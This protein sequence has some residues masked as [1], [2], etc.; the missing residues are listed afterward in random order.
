MSDEPFI[1]F[2][3]RFENSRVRKRFLSQ[4][5]PMCKLLIRYGMEVRFAE[6]LISIEKQDLQF[7]VFLEEGERRYSELD[8]IFLVSDARRKG[9]VAANQMRGILRTLV[10]WGAL[11][12]DE[13]PSEEIDKAVDEAR[14]KCAGCC[15]AQMFGERFKQC[16][17]CRDNDMAARLPEFKGFYCCMD[18]QR[19]DWTRH[20]VEDH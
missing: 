5:I 17:T 2:A 8:M 9:S 19:R 15:R 10:R 11:T 14:I 12:K 20:K 7:F 13:I 6:T 18:C 16:R 4:M 3:K 1:P